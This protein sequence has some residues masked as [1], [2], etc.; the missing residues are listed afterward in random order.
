MARLRSLG[1]MIFGRSSWE[2]EAREE[3]RFHI[4]RRA[5]DLSA[6]GMAPEEAL[7]RARIEF[8]SIESY[9]ERCREARGARWLDEFLRNLVYAFRSI[10]K[11]PGF[12]GI[13]VLTLAL[14]I[15]GNTALFTLVDQLLLQDLP[16]RDARDL[17]SLVWST[18]RFKDQAGFPL[19]DYEAFQR[20]TPVLADVAAVKIFERVAVEGLASPE[21][22]SAEY[23]SGN[24]FSILGVHPALGRL[25]EPADEAVSSGNV[26]VLSFGCW[27]RRFHG[28]PA[29]IGR[30][31]RIDSRPVTI[32]G[33]TP[34]HF[35]GLSPGYAPEFRMPL[36]AKPA[37]AS[38]RQ[39]QLDSLGMIVGH[40]QKGVGRPQAEAY[41]RPLYA[42]REQEKAQ[43]LPEASRAGYLS[44]Q[45]VLEVKPANHGLYGLNTTYEKPLWIVFALAGT[46]LL[47]VCVN[48][49]G[50]LISQGERR[51]H[52][53]RIRLAIGASRG[54]ILRQFLT[55]S[56]LL[57]LCGSLVGVLFAWWAS[58][59]IVSFVPGGGFGR[60][61]PVEIGAGF[62][63]RAWLFLAASSILTAVL[64]GFPPA[65]RS[66][67]CSLVLN[68]DSHI[69]A[70]GRRGSLQNLVLAAQVA[71]SL[72]LVLGA[73]TLIGSLRKLLTENPGY[74]KEQ[75]LMV[76]IDPTT[77]RYRQEQAPQFFNQLLA[78]V[79]GMPGVQS[80]SLAR[81]NPLG[82]TFAVAA[83]PIAIEGHPG[84]A[85]DP[86]VKWPIR[87]VIA[88]NYFRT[89]RLPLLR[90][91]DFS[92]TDGPQ[93]QRVTI[94]N[95]QFV[96][97]YFG[98]GN[99]LGRRIGWNRRAD[100]EI[101]GVVGNGKYADLRESAKPY[102]YIPYAQVEPSRWQQ[103]TL[104][105]K[106]SGDPVA[107][108]A[109]TRK[110]IA[111]LDSTLPIFQITTMDA[112]V[113]T[114]LSRERMVAALGGFFGVLAALLA[115]VGTYGVASQAVTRRMKEIGIR[116]TLGAQR[117]QI[118]RAVVG[119]VLLMLVIGIAVGLCFLVMWRILLSTFV[120]GVTATDLWVVGIA[121]GIVG[122][123]A[124]VATSGPVTRAVS[125]DPVVTLRYE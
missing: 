97:Q 50:L 70:S 67:R 119:D 39:R 99:P 124:L 113:N 29:V 37:P 21:M 33:V 1:R 68:G 121:I 44:R 80:A 79:A 18:P 22:A 57:S 20:A 101:V 114:H 36:S 49:A 38:E 56:L 34:S 81:Y 107:V 2:E 4:E 82:P 100:I 92:D 31:I 104:Q 48:I 115:A 120:Y 41:L 23:V 16:V 8:G 122:G 25:I 3:L 87:N 85:A 28:D 73:T 65:A 9:H 42:A 111:A 69:S 24:Y 32:V 83:M 10:Q 106:V 45:A 105:V 88:P 71:L 103:M 5:E 91:R 76:S 17:I 77:G 102:W 58:G 13:A 125:V 96:D 27:Q 53:T 62:T 59:L 15:G 11:S 90:G 54:Q 116:M 72:S 66:T 117:W 78:R 47:V 95:Q 89:L 43:Y 7:R 55:E 63:L 26:T 30:T 93:S 112:E 108:A 74:S 75:L 98:G 6:A 14:G 52:E 123:I 64:F 61:L 60:L 86:S 12:A 94:V 51:Q 46:V 19:R 35:Y 84:Q 118:V 110:E 109:A 40:L